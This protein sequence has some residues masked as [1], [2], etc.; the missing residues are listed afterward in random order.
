VY[1]GGHQLGLYQSSD[2]IPFRGLLKS[3]GDKVDLCARKFACT[4]PTQ[5]HTTP[6][7]TQ[8]AVV[9]TL[10][11]YSLRDPGSPPVHHLPAYSRR[12]L[13]CPTTVRTNP[14]PSDEVR[15]PVESLL[16]AAGV[17]SASLDVT[18]SPSVDN[19]T[20]RSRGMVITV[21]IQYSRTASARCDLLPFPLLHGDAGHGLGAVALKGESTSR[22][23]SR[24]RVLVTGCLSCSPLLSRSSVP[25]LSYTITANFVA[26]SGYTLYHFAPTAPGASWKYLE[27]YGVR[28]SVLHGGGWA[29][30]VTLALGSPQYCGL[31]PSSF[32]TSPAETE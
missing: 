23:W 32:L 8:Q 9:H 24:Q 28:L 12:G 6:H 27:L 16:E 14:S 22:D 21:M 31:K 19:S 26:G 30:G 7:H 17:P 25:D 10:T 20:Y 1:P 5:H 15:L 11:Q 3:N 18:R 2:R 29:F 4:L 13:P